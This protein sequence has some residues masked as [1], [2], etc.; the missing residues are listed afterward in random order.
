MDTYD[1][2]T[3][4]ICTTILVLA[5]ALLALA[6]WG[7]R[8]YRSTRR[9]DRRSAAIHGAL[10]LIAH[11]LDSIP[12]SSGMDSSTYRPTVRYA[13]DQLERAAGTRPVPGDAHRVI[14]AARQAAL[15]VHRV[16]GMKVGPR[17]LT[18]VLE[19][20]QRTVAEAGTRTRQL[21]LTE[22]RGPVAM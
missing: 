4:L 13:L 22:Q 3:V 11:V 1:D 9:R 12:R 15:R 21:L 5:G 16:L 10:E 7:L 17:L 19:R 6:M 18:K 2:Q 8:V 20:A 14:S